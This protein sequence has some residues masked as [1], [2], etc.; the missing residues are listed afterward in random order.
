MVST[1]TSQQL[2]YSIS[3][4]MNYSMPSMLHFLLSSMLC[5][6]KNMTGKNRRFIAISISQDCKAHNLILLC[7]SKILSEA[8]STELFP[9][10]LC[11]WSWK[12]I[13][14]QQ[15]GAQATCG[16]VDQSYSST[17]SWSATLG[18]SSWATDFLTGYWYQYSAAS[19]FTGS[20]SGYKV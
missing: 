17:L 14:S 3:T 20:Y 13:S 5:S 6:M 7:I 12:M 11:F 8:S 2:W 4:I 18:S 15:M 16:K 1:H 10:L 9:L 19:V